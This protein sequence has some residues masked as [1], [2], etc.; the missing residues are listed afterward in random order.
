[1]RPVLS[2]GDRE[3]RTR[4][5]TATSADAG[6]CQLHRRPDSDV[7]TRAVRAYLFSEPV[8][9]GEPASVFLLLR[10]EVMHAVRIPAVAG[11]PENRT[12]RVFNFCVAV[13]GQFQN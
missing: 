1:T 2:R 6:R 11:S 9:A 5:Q 3:S 12:R 4:S 7:L 13:S 8:D 10:I